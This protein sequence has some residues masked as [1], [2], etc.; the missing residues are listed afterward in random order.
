MVLRSMTYYGN[1][2]VSA[3]TGLSRTFMDKEVCRL[4]THLIL[5]HAFL[6]GTTA[7]V[8][9]VQFPGSLYADLAEVSVACWKN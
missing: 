4:E 9:L 2:S 5:S 7:F 8:L 1:D 3:F 6:H